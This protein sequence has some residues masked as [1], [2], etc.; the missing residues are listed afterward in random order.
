MTGELRYLLKKGILFHLSR[1][2]QEAGYSHYLMLQ[3]EQVSQAFSVNR[4]RT[5]PGE[6]G[7]L[8]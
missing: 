3:T 2:L 4:K 5:P 1:Y 8:S 6:T 7:S